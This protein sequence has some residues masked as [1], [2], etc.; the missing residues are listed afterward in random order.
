MSFVDQSLLTIFAQEQPEHIARIRKLLEVAVSGDVPGNQPV[1]EE[2]LR[3]LHTLKGAARAVGLEETEQLMHQA[4]DA[5]L[6]AQAQNLPLGLEIATAISKSMDAA[7]DILAQS[8]R[9][10]K[11]RSATKAVASRPEAAGEAGADATLLVRVHSERVDDLIRDSSGLLGH[12][13]LEEERERAGRTWE[14]LRYVNRGLQRLTRPKREARGFQYRST[15]GDGAG[16]LVAVSRHA[17]AAEREARSLFERLQNRGP[18][19]RERATRI[20]EDACSIRLTSSEL[21]LGGFGAMLRD[22]AQQESKEIAFHINGL[23]SHADRLVLQGLKEPVMHLLRNAVSHGIEPP[24][25]RA[26]AGKPPVGTVTLEAML[27]A[28]RLILS[29]E[30]DG[31]GLD[32]ELLRKESERRGIPVPEDR[33]EA[34]EQL[35]KL[36]FRSGLSTAK[37]VTGVSG[38]GIGLS[39][40]QGA[41]QRL[42]GDLRFE[43]REGGGSRVVISV[44]VAISTEHVLLVSAGGHTFGIGSAFVDGLHRVRESETRMIG[45]RKA[46]ITEEGAVDLVSLASL[47]DLAQGELGSEENAVLQCAVV[48]NGG[49]KAALVVSRLLDAGEMVIKDATLPETDLGLITAAIPLNDGGVAPL[50]N[51]N[52]LF[53]LLGRSPGAGALA[54]VEQARNR[55]RR[56]LVVDDSLTTR[57]LEKSILEAHGYEVQL[58]V[59]GIEALE[60]VRTDPPELVISDVMMPRLTGFQLLERIRGEEAIKHIPVILVTSL[61]SRQEQELGLSLGADAYIVKR[62]F[63]QRELLE[64]IEQIL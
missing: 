13:S 60:R 31:R 59:D 18:V 29:I 64:T 27:R 3:R 32:Y 14:L 40:V 1:M 63:D 26:A 10:A 47:L 4:E 22:I 48:K 15:G 28:D 11:L 41:V 39:V 33:R 9:V 17:A 25:V 35:A 23:Q 36:I 2:L 6:P 58:A 52:S 49:A 24:A 38:R 62:K 46:L 54:P 56:I 45:G 21:F 8:L 50:L 61:E 55:K 30:D 20:Y 57:S 37:S 16:E 34:R 44:P 42:R 7:E 5:L 51:V 19:L 53:E 43:D 12:A